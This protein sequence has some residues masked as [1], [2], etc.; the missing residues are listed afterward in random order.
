LYGPGFLRD[1]VSGQLLLSG[2]LPQQQQAPLKTFGNVNPDWVGGWANE[3][4]Y[5]SLSLNTLLDVRRGGSTFS[6]GN[7]WGTYAGVL[8]E[9]LKGREVDWDTPGIVV[10]GLDATTKTANTIRVTAEE[11]RH[12]IYPVV[13]PY[14]YNSGFIKFREARLSW[15]VPSRLAAKA[16]VAQMNIALVGRNLFTWTDYPNYDPENAT[17][18]SNAGQGLEMGSLPTNKSIGINLTITP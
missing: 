15:E 14:I 2:G 13:E 18:A 4:R 17:N 3:I 7:M 11:Y 12:S 5:K 6:I 9:S 1:S 10:Q 16:R 8:K